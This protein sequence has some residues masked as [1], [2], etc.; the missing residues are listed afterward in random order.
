MNV[1]VWDVN[2][3]NQALICSRRPMDIEELSDPNA[4]LRLKRT[5]RLRVT[6]ERYLDGPASLQT[7]SISARLIS[8]LVLAPRTAGGIT[9]RLLRRH[10]SLLEK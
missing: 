4:P 10:R 2:E 1:N 7:T 5:G 8:H 6:H 9:R 3:H